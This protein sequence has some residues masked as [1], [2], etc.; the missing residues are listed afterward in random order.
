VTSGAPDAS[1]RW[2]DLHAHSTA[3]DGALSPAAM[4]GAAHRAGLAAL[5]LTDHDS[6]DGLPEAQRAARALGIAIVPGVEL[7]AYEGAR[8]VHILGLHLSRIEELERHLTALRSARR[9]RAERIV[10]RLATLQAPVALDRVLAIAGPGA[11]GRPHIAQALLEAGHVK[12]RREA[13]DRFLGAGR[14]AFFSKHRL[15]MTEAVDM[16]HQAGGLAILAHPGPQ[17]TR[18]RLERFKSQGGDGVEV[19]HPGHTP[20]D[21]ARIGA[22]AETLRLVPSGGSDCHGALEGPRCLGGMQ[23]PGEWLDRQVDRVRERATT[24][25]VA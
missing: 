21:I 15:T 19:R 6:V 10:E 7:S 25:R 20:D 3:S 8:E 11:I 18:E 14:P 17:G 5:A 24:G 1:A 23:V 2:V 13:F 16:I 12:D 22:L 9:S 4:V